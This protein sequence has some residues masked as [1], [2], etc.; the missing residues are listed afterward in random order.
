MCGIAGSAGPGAATQVTVVDVMAERLRHRGPDASGTRSFDDCVLGH[1]RLRIIDLSPL[2][3]Q[4]MANED[5]T[6]WAVFNGEIYNFRELRRDLEGAGHRFRSDSDTEVLTHLYEER[7]VD[8]ALR[9]RGMFAFAV[10]DDTRRRLLL[11]RDRLGIKPLYY[12]VEG[13]RLS[14]AS[15]VQAL[16]TPDDALDPRAIAGYLRLGWVPGPG[17][18]HTGVSELLPAQALVWEGGRARTTTYWSPPGAEA[19]SAPP[20]TGDLGAVLRDAMGRHL[21]ADVPV[22]LFLSSGVDSVALARLAADVA[23]GLQ[24]YT[25]AFDA[26]A[27]ESADAA[28]LAR[29][30]GIANT[31]VHVGED[32]A[33]A[34]L[35]PFFAGMDQPTVDGLNSWLVSRAVREAGAVVALSGLGGDELFGGYSTFR[36]VPRLVRVSRRLGPL[37]VMPRAAGQALG[38]SSRTAGWRGRRAVE[39]VAGG[40]WGDAYGAVRG[41]FSLA[42]LGRLWP[43]AR[44]FDTAAMVRGPDAAGAPGAAGV[45]TLEVA[46]YLPFQLLRDTDCM[47]M[48]HGLEVRVVL[49]DDAVFELVAR[50]RSSGEAWGKADLIGAVDP[51]LAWLARRPKRTFTLPIDRWMRGRLEAVAEE[52]FVGLGEAGLGFDRRALTDVWHGYLGGR[53]HWRPVWALTVLGRWVAERGGRRPAAVLAPAS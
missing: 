45:G 16:S 47:S 48:A 20:P 24:S 44:Q 15:E 51:G 33:M 29:R 50:R 38:W 52:A 13:E 27:D 39:A 18:I 9:L 40:G 31:V 14:F 17:T 22:G 46:N 12:R 37:A 26:S 19:G 49:L 28:A 35:A 34:A 43:P 2:G 42:E 7:G 25:V 3:D 5:G 30:I 8:M 6:V 4:P 1:T 36:H 11:C 21:V 32:D 41:L 53:V 10:W 23:P